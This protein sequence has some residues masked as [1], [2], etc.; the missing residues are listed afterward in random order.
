MMEPSQL[1]PRLDAMRRTI[2]RRLVGYGV[3]SVLAGGVLSF[4]TITALDWLLWLPVQLRLLGGLLFVSG[5]V[6][7]AYHW[8]GRPLKAPLGIEGIAARLEARFPHLQ[9]RL[10]S[11]VNFVKRRD[12]GSA[13][14]MRQVVINTDRVV[15]DL[16]LEAALTLRPLALRAIAF[17]LAATVLG[18]ILFVSPNW[19]RTGFLRY[20]APFSALEW[21]R[22]VAIVPLTG[23]ELV[24]LGESATVRMAIARGWN[25]RL[26]SVVRFREEGGDTVSRAMQRDMDGSFYATID[27]VTADLTYWFEAGDDSTE[28]APLMIRVVRRPKVVEALA[29]VE[30][31]SYAVQRGIHTHDLQD[32]PLHAPI[33]GH[34]TI[35]VRAS[36]P[37]HP[38]EPMA[39]E[40]ATIGLWTESEEMIPLTIDPD[41]PHELSA[42]FR[43]TG[44]RHFRVRLRDK[45]GFENRGARRY[46]ILATPDSPPI[47]TIV[48]PPAVTELT[49]FG[50]VSLLIRVEDD[51]GVTRLIL[52]VDRN[53]GRERTIL[54]LTDHLVRSELDA[55]V[56]AIAAYRMSMESLSLV[57]GDELMFTAAAWDN[58]RT[59]GMTEQVGRSQPQR[60]RVISQVEFDQRVRN[61]LAQL[62]ERVRQAM[63]DESDLLD[64]TTALASSDAEPQALS[65]EEHT[66]V[67]RLSTEQARLIRRLRHLARRFNSLRKRIERNSG[68][69]VATGDQMGSLEKSLRAIA[70]GPLTSA[71]NALSE[72]SDRVHATDQRAAVEKAARHQETGV[73]QLRNLL[74]SLAQRSDFQELVTR[75]HDLLDRQNAIRND[76]TELSKSL[77]GQSVEALSDAEI[78]MLNRT[79]RRQEQLATDVA[80]LL[81]RMERLAAA[82]SGEDPDGADAI[83]AALRM[84]RAHD[85]NNRMRA[86]AHA[87]KANR[88]AAATI[89]QRRAEQALRKMIDALRERD[90]R[91]LARLEKRLRRI[92]DE[93]AE[94]IDQQQALRT[95]TVEAALLDAR[96]A[97]LHSL[98]LQQHTLQKNT[99]H[100]G[101]ELAEMDRATEAARILR[102]AAVA[103]GD[104]ETPL[105]EGLARRA[106][107]A[108]NEALAHLEDALARLVT[109]AV[110]AA[111]QS[112]RRSLARIEETLRAMR[113]AQV[114][115]NTGIEK[116][117]A[118]IQARNRVGR[119]EARLSSRLAR[120]QAGVAALGQDV[121]PE[122]K[123]VP[124]YEWALQ[125]VGK[126]IDTS[127]D[128][129]D[130]REIDDKLVAVSNR[131]VRE[132]DRLLHA[133]AETEGLPM[134]TEFTEAEGGGGAR[135]RSPATRPVPAVAE[136]LVLKAM[137][138][139]INR[140]TG[141]MHESLDMSRVSETELGR[142]KM[143]G[144]D[145]AEVRRLTELVTRQANQP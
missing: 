71:G 89:D 123:Q 57:P 127:R 60:I 5:F 14:M 18:G 134:E 48:E 62:E 8:I 80:R 73:D 38:G 49:P 141:E 131:I 120:K 74:E 94:L 3:F 76:T 21:P 27:A 78:T 143:L 30:P 43:V 85:V 137:Q 82:S 44:D 108:Q 97:E 20:F 72:A 39:T 19:A 130:A 17:L 133:I 105:L 109:L 67:A 92:E 122:L 56:V 41:D 81:A 50:S 68:A 112:L 90:R 12:A 22:Q 16:P 9:D 114:D 106:S 47:V 136:L 6:A 100:V 142:L 111:N 70:A 28:S 98:A 107:D 53:T 2:R 117:R 29:D 66:L 35:H 11:T 128:Q 135:G 25:D 24:A 139:D 45:N 1:L 96:A 113:V 69:S 46:S 26:R 125:R 58:R 10:S 104:A 4:L 119:K 138:V 42:R 121:L 115:V 37:I 93:V 59:E 86:A 99:R 64:G 7:A 15:K 102:L 13:T 83:E 132:L 52:E 33:G 77:L 129:L 54:P 145:Q 34:V 103:M 124:V 116:L 87:I 65:R 79:H 84:A 101:R 61:D 31:P 126:W 88:T 63:L 91:E 55:G 40:V 95:A 75:T 140:Q 110:E 51:F 36:K 32:G 144:E 23:T 118:A